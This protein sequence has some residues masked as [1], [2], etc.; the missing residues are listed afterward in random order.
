MSN[1]NGPS[2]LGP[3]VNSADAGVGA[4]CVGAPAAPCPGHL[5]VRVRTPLD[6]PIQGVTVEV[7]G[8]G[9]KLTGA[10]GRADFGQVPATTYNITAHK[11][12]FGPLPTGA[13]PFAVGNATAT[14]AVPSGATVS[15][16]MRMVTVT[17]VTVTHT[18]VVA[19]TPLRIYKQAAGDAHVDHIIVCNALCP[20]TAG[21]GAGTQFPV[22]VD[23][24]FTAPAANAPKANGG[25]DDT[26]VHF[27]LATGF[28]M[29]GAGTK[30]ASTVTN[31]SGATQ[32]TLRASVTSGDHFIVHAKVLRD[33]ANAAAGDLGHADSPNFEVWKKLAY[34]NL[35]RMKTGAN[36]GFDLEA[37]C[38]V[39]N[40]QP[41]FTPTFTEYSVGAAHLVAYK[42]YITDLVVPTAAQLPLNGT[43]QVRSDGDDTRV[44]TI[45]G[46]VVA[47]DGST[48]NSTEALTLNGTAN[49]VGAK[50]FQKIAQVT[51]PASPTRKLTVETS[52]GAAV[53]TVAA[54]AASASPNFLFDTVAAVQTKAQAWYDANNAQ[55]GTDLAALNTSIG[56]AG[57]FMIGAAWYHPKKDGRP[58]T[59][60]TTYYAGYPTLLIH[61]YDKSF[62]PD[63]NWEGVDGVNQ[64]QMSC[65]FINVGGGAYASMVAR[66][67]IGHAS[68]HVNYGP[69][70]HCPQVTCLMY[71]S[72]Q[73]NQFCTI[74][75]D[76]SQH[77]TQGW[78]P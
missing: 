29:S 48:S 16:E 41:A 22:R 1:G 11:A 75:P 5:I 62:H 46:L 26:D 54:H 76:H 56:A 6:A 59:G 32:I 72:S 55:L 38:T 25:K 73:Q 65:L 49:V 68:D 33:P 60:L 23:W 52:A 58:A 17:S 9:H 42:E 74:N 4:G 39:P 37:R 10:D 47:A 44:V 64:G 67:E 45:H 35:Y 51:V 13:S 34:N 78:T 2:G 27:G 15:A 50:K 53:A 7:T 3:A 8:R 31:D 40:I 20:K 12:D 69:G 21:N 14:Q 19:A 18:P 43:V 66:H 30:T 36:A 61:Y 57:Y 77:R 70:D 71:H 28:P 24:T 63:K